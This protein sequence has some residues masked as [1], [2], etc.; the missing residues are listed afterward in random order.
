[1]E[2]CDT[3]MPILEKKDLHSITSAIALRNQE[4]K[5]A[6]KTHSKQK[7]GNKKLELITKQKTKR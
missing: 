5:K 1:M 3:K 4:G 6:N 2:I 7:K